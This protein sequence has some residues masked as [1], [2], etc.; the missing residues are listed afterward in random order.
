MRP[1]LWTLSHGAESL[2]ANPTARS[3]QR[4]DAGANKRSKGNCPDYG[5]RDKFITNSNHQT[6][7]RAGLIRTMMAL[8]SFVSRMFCTHIVRVALG[9]HD[10]Q[11]VVVRSQI[12]SVNTAPAQPLATTNNANQTYQGC[13]SGAIVTVTPWCTIL[14]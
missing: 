13:F 1:S 9:F 10:A 8:F 5:C 4:T 7:V 11:H 6:L 14:A 12:H 3:I 2:Y